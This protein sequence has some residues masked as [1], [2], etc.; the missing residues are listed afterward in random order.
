M[1]IQPPPVEQNGQTLT[2]MTTPQ[3]PLTYDENTQYN[4]QLPLVVETL[5]TYTQQLYDRYSKTDFGRSMGYAIL[6]YVVF[7]SFR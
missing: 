2:S 4:F 6:G 1:I 5:T 3:A 7:L